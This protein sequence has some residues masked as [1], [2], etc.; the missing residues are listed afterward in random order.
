MAAPTVSDAVSNCTN[1][2]AT[3]YNANCTPPACTDDGSCVYPNDPNRCEDNGQRNVAV[4]VKVTNA[5]LEMVWAI[6]DQM[7]SPHRY[8]PFSNFGSGG[9]EMV[10][11]MDGGSGSG[12]DHKFQYQGG[13][14]GY[15]QINGLGAAACP[16]AG[17]ESCVLLGDQLFN[18]QGGDRQVDFHVGR[19][20]PPPPIDPQVECSTKYVAAYMQFTPGAQCDSTAP[21]TD[22]CQELIT[23]VL[24]TCQNTTFQN[25]SPPTCINSKG[26]SVSCELSSDEKACKTASPDCT[27]T[28][29]GAAH[30]FDENAVQGLQKMGP[31]DC[32]YSLGYEVRTHRLPSTNPLFHLLAG[33]VHGRCRSPFADMQRPSVHSEE[34]QRPPRHVRWAGSVRDDALR[35]PRVGIELPRGMRAAVRFGQ[36]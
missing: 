35:A 25:G 17:E 18:P 2:F 27:Y 9:A 15:V 10:L 24:R 1:S 34:L 11:C 5:D 8:G 33:E 22:V 20:P 36:L 21:C 13:G 31:K 30:T 23:D 32:D 4:Q 3:N 12:M 29:H 19:A 7:M 26:S 16:Q 14:E 6:D 28:E